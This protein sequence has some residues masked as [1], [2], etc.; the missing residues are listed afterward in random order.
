MLENEDE[1][2]SVLDYG[3]NE[4]EVNNAINNSNLKNTLNLEGTPLEIAVEGMDKMSNEEF[5]KLRRNGFGT[6]DSSILLKVNPFTTFQ[7]LIT[8]KATPYLTEEEKAVGELAAVRKG[9]DLEPLIIEKTMKALETTLVKPKDMYRLTD[10][11]YLTLNYDGVG[12]YEKDS[13]FA[14]VAGINDYAPNEIKVATV[15]GE[16]YY[17]IP[18]A[19]YSEQRLYWGQDPW[20]EIPLPLTELQLRTMTIEEKAAYYGIPKYY[21]TQVQQQM[22][23]FKSAGGFISALFEVDW[24]L[25]IWLVWADPVVQ[26]ALITEGFKADAMVTQAKAR[27]SII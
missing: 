5:A 18:K 26:S 6:S 21:Y 2:V 23:G 19:I 1:D 16:R 20:G 8:Q 3:I 13:K 25:H 7:E 4:A 15:K 27:Q 9:N 17:T 10:F 14:A 24:H 22:M 12:T 11:P